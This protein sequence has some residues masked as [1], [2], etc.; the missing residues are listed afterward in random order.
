[1][2][3]E[4]VVGGQEPQECAALIT[5]RSGPRA[6][7]PL[8]SETVGNAG[9]DEPTMLLLIWSFVHLPQL[10]TRFPLYEVKLKN[11]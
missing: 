11:I 3:S 7:L 2:L 10:M 8:I 4:R 5:L 9:W 6:D 1:M